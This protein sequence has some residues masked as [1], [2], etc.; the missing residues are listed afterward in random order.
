MKK[1]MA[2]LVGILAISPFVASAEEV[3]TNFYTYNKGDIVNFYGSDAQKEAHQAGTEEGG[4]ETIIFNDK[5]NTDEFVEAWLLG[6]YM[7]TSVANTK[8]MIKDFKTTDAYSFYREVLT[9]HGVLPATGATHYDYIYD[10][11]DAERGLRM[12]TIADMTAVFGATKEN[13]TDNYVF[14]NLTTKNL[15]DRNGQSYSLLDEFDRVYQRYL[16]DGMEGLENGILLADRIGDTS[17][18][19]VPTGFKYYAIKFTI[20]D[21]KVTDAKIEAVEFQNVS[22]KIGIIPVVSINKSAD[23]H[24]TPTPK[25]MCYICGTEPKYVEEGTQGEGCTEVPGVSKA[26]DC[27]YNVCYKCK[28]ETEEGKFTYKID[29]YGKTEYSECEIVQDSDCNTKTGKKSYILEF[30]IVAALC[31]ISL[32]VVKRKELFRTI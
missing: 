31:T 4:M 18:N 20:T 2:I 27:V 26:E 5:G 21:N 1:L 32:L 3:S 10:L 15:L 9:N 30:A 8:L 24:D 23:C 7:G 25:Y 29:R 19:T 13:G 11:D 6:E 22:Q 17:G 16:A 28:S 14:P 12:P